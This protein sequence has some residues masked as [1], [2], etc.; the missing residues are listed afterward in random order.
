M[1]FI[2]FMVPY[3]VC[4]NLKLCVSNNSTNGI[5]HRHF[6]N[7]TNAWRLSKNHTENPLKTWLLVYYKMFKRKTIRFELFLAYLVLD[8]RKLDNIIMNRKERNRMCES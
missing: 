8:Q 1:T 3:E 2:Q 7:R 4:R 6:D 5:K